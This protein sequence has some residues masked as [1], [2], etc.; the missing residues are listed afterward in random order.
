METK[1]KVQHEEQEPMTMQEA[2]EMLHRMEVER[3]RWWSGMAD[4]RKMMR[5]EL[6]GFGV[7][8]QKIGRAH[9]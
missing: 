2:M 7:K 3:Y 5:D 9:V 4:L 6:M 1:W 8:R